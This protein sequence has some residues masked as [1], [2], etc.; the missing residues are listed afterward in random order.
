MTEHA[1][2]SSHRSSTTSTRT[3][4][5]SGTHTAAKNRY[6]RSVCKAHA[7]PQRGARRRGAS[8]AWP[9]AAGRVR[10][11]RAPC[12]RRARA[13]RA[14]AV[15]RRSAGA[16]RGTSAAAAA[17]RRRPLAACAGRAECARMHRLCGR[18]PL[19]HKGPGPQ[20]SRARPRCCWRRGAAGA[21]AHR[22]TRGACGQEPC[23]GGAATSST[24]CPGAMA[25][26]SRLACRCRCARAAA[27]FRAVGAHGVRGSA[28]GAPAR[29]QGR[30]ARF[31]T[32]FTGTAGSARTGAEPQARHWVRPRPCTALCRCTRGVRPRAS[33]VHRGRGTPCRLGGAARG[34]PGSPARGGAGDAPR[35]VVRRLVRRAGARARQRRDVHA[36]HARQDAVAQAALLRLAPRLPRAAAVDR[37]RC[38]RGGRRRGGRR[39]AG[40]AGGAAPRAGRLRAQRRPG[41]H[42]GRGHPDELLLG[43][44]LRSTRRRLACTPRLLH[45]APQGCAWCGAPAG[46]TLLRDR[47]D[48]RA[49]QLS[50]TCVRICSAA[51]MGAAGGAARLHGQHLDAHGVGCAHAVRARDDLPPA[52]SISRAAG[53]MARRRAGALRI[54]TTRAWRP[55]PQRPTRIA[56]ARTGAAAHRAA[57][58]SRA[59]SGLGRRGDLQQLA[60]V[61]QRLHEEHPGHEAQVQAQRARAVHQQHAHLVVVLRVRTRVSTTGSLAAA[62]AFV[63]SCSMTRA[64]LR[65]E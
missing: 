43:C 58:G 64:V 3:S 60:R 55:N 27:L 16:R 6:S 24:A 34:V 18:R 10:G 2:L 22:I 40:C 52:L 49:A 57:L 28:R 33:W 38:R 63:H 36:A 19:R 35:R 21:Y 23:G 44:A 13:R 26:S 48:Q 7:E 47:L 46:R 59:A 25:S 5:T 1:C 56:S 15:R 54:P 14:R 29:T 30:A 39:R 41:A 11:R 42:R 45:D 65:P 32:R 12:S 20:G 61:L 50:I 8:G 17:M 9:H 51:G 53:F 62:R 37:H 4:S 31:Q